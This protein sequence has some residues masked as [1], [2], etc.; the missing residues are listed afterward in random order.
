M[1][2]KINQKLLSASAPKDQPSTSIAC[3]STPT[4]IPDADIKKRFNL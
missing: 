2:T 4:A 3:A 1:F